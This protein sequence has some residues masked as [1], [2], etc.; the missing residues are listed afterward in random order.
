MSIDTNALASALPAG[1]S[2]ETAPDG[3]GMTW[4]V[5]E[6]AAFQAECLAQTGYVLLHPETLARDEATVERLAEVFRSEW[7]AA[8]ERGEAG[9][10]VTHGLR[11]VLAA[12]AAA[13]D[14]D[15]GQDEGVSG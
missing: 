12:L 8:D 13:P 6:I 5:P 10:R 1:I 11:A 15:S 9:Q 2:Y 3:A 4:R 7:H 14:P